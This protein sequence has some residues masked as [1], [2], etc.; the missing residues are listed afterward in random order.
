MFDNARTHHAQG[1][2]L[3]NYC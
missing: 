3:D 2:P 1:D